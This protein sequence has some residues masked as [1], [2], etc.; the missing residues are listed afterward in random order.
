MFL[1]LVIWHERFELRVRD[2]LNFLYFMRRAKAIHAME[3]RHATVERG[4]MSNHGHIMG[5]LYA[6]RRENG[7]TAGAHQHSITMVAINGEGFPRQ[8]PTGHMY[9]GW[10]ELTGDFVEI[11]DAE[12]KTLT[13][14]V[15][16][17]QGAGHEGPMQ[18][19]GC[20]RNRV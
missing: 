10:Q 3:K 12:K 6:E 18:R 17:G 13:G 4:H 5:F 15:G 9:H 16:G 14:G 20:K 7:P 2:Q 19:T 11:G 8:R 1:D